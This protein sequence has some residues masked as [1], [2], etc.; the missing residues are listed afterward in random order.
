MNKYAESLLSAFDR[1]KFHN[2][3]SSWL[4]ARCMRLFTKVRTEE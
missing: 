4:L 3:C 1:S 2:Q